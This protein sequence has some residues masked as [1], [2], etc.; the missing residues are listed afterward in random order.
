MSEMD[1][2]LPFV[3][4]L[5]TIG[6]YFL[7][8]FIRSRAHV[9]IPFKDPISLGFVF[10]A[11][12]P[13]IVDGVNHTQIAGNIWTLSITFAFFL[14]YIIG[15]LAE[16]EDL[17]YVAVHQIVER[18]QEI[19]PIVR[20]YN[21]DGKCCWQPQSFKEII[22]TMVFGIHNPL[23]LSG[24]SRTRYVHLKKVLMEL[25]A[26]AVDL[27]G[28]EISEEII[29]KGPFKFR[30]ESRRYIP[31]PLCQDSPY[32]FITK[33]EG[34]EEL[35]TKFADMQ[36]DAAESKAQLSVAQV[37]GGAA[38]LNALAGKQPSN[39][40]MD[41]LGLEMDEIIGKKQKRR[42]HKKIQEAAEEEMP[43]VEEE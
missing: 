1:M 36:V 42:I 33:A 7:G 19:E 41:E 35:F 15:Y 16:Q 5:I 43:E 21:R 23:Q 28:V 30:I 10:L 4:V 37:K 13:L 20:Y 3:V 22:K 25:S 18:T 8:K 14:G 29:K 12:V 40:Y 2:G 11:F 9:I 27:A 31:C 38:M 34:Y 39:V 26:D 6:S 32:D 24:G 17:V